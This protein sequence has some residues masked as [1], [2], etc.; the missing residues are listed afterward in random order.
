MALNFIETNLAE[1]YFGILQIDQR[2]NH[3]E[4][5]FY[6]LNQVSNNTKKSCRNHIHP[7]SS[8]SGPRRNYVRRVAHKSGP[9]QYRINSL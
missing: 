6:H 8:K 1:H 4:L 7:P 3:P 2:P 5:N 9:K